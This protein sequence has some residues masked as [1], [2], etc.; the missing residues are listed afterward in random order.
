MLKLAYRLLLALSISAFSLYSHAEYVVIVNKSNTTAISQA[1]I[2]RMYL[3]KTNAFSDG[4]LAIPLNHEEGTA[5]RIAFDQEIVGRSE[6]QM[7]AYWARLLFTGRAT[8]I[9]QMANDAEMMELVA[10]NPSTIGY[11]KSSS[12][13]DTVKV[14]MNF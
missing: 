11:V 9:K 3:A 2:E 5:I 14:L 1:D 8:P 7:K 13:D 4:A 6:S 12:A 10:K